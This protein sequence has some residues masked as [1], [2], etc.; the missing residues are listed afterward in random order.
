[1]KLI[2]RIV[3]LEKLINTINTPDIKAITGF[4]RAGKCQNY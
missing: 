1:M 3:Y 2:E 4:R